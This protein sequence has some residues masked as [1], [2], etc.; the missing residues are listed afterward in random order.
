MARRGTRL[1]VSKHLLP[2][3]GEFDPETLF[4]KS[5]GFGSPTAGNEN[6]VGKQT[7]KEPSQ[8]TSKA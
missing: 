2:G 4:S 6:P 3:S 1:Y 7:R 8:G 5:W